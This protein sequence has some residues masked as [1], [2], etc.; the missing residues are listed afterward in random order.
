VRRDGACVSIPIDELV[1]GDIVELIAGDLVPADSRLLESR[2]LFINQALL[3][4][5]LRVGSPAILNDIAASRR[6][7]GIRLQ[8]PTSWSWRLT[9]TS[10]GTK[11]HI[12]SVDSGRLRRKNIAT[13][14]SSRKAW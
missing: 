12:W 6:R 14:A 10:M 7:L 13:K 8:I 9:G 11:F 5:E 3:T 1:P 2:D 4:G